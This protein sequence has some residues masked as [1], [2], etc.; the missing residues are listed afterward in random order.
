[1]SLVLSS[2]INTW[3]F[4]YGIC[5]LFLASSCPGN[6]SGPWYD[7]AIERLN[8][9]GRRAFVSRTTILN[10]DQP[11]LWHSVSSSSQ[12]MHYT[13]SCLMCQLSSH[14]LFSCLLGFVCS[15]CGF[16]NSFC[17]AYDSL[18]RAEQQFSTAL[19]TKALY[20]TCTFLLGKG[21]WSLLFD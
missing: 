13:F 12:E 18:E 1:M 14:S 9:G 19:L 21:Y 5:K 15:L 7:K 3:C 11:F 10:H 2:C 4:S 16:K 20:V 6:C 17:P 8:Q